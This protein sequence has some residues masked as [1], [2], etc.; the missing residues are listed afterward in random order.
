MR[1]T[2]IAAVFLGFAASA[3][4]ASADV[5]AFKSTCVKVTVGET[6]QAC[7]SSNGKTLSSRF[8]WKNNPTTAVHTGCALRG[9]TIYCS[10]GRW[11]NATGSGPHLP[12][13]VKLANGRPVSAA[14]SH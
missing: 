8:V 13:T 4:N 9:D 6:K 14:V 5:P 12:V 10:G 3:S 7:V 11:K 2:L 1:F